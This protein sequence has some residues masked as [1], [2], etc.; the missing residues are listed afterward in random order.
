MATTAFEVDSWVWMP[1][2][3]E[4]YL[5]AKVWK[6]GFNKGDEGKVKTE[7]GE[8]HTL[9]AKVT[10]DLMPCNEEVLSSDVDNLI[11]LNDLN[12]QAILHNLR[13]RFKED[14]IYTYVSTIL[15]M[16]IPSSCCRC[17]RQEMLDKQG[18]GLSRPAAPRLR[19]L[20][21]TPTARCWA[22]TAAS[23]SSSLASPA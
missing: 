11:K 9:S 14:Q 10:A 4:M 18:A 12:E 7:D 23:L 5:P 3:D 21:I 15:I 6:T 8:T 16:S 2:D 13:I 1:D 20:A 17:T 19:R 22:T